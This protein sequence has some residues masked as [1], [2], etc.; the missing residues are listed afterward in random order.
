MPSR[1]KVVFVREYREYGW[2]YYGADSVKLSKPLHILLGNYLVDYEL[3]AS[4]I[5]IHKRVYG[6]NEVQKVIFTQA[7]SKADGLLVTHYLSASQ[8]AQI[9]QRCEEHPRDDGFHLAVTLVKAG[10][11][12]KFDWSGS[13]E[14]NLLDLLSVV[15]KLAPQKYIFYEPGQQESFKRSLQYSNDTQ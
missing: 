11:S 6:R 7:L 8:P 15:N 1:D 3:D 12:T 4:K 9:A 2:R 14:P 10:R 5:V 13:H